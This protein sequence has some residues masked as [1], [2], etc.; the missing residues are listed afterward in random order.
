MPGFQAVRIDLR[1]RLSREVV[2]WHLQRDGGNAENLTGSR[3]FQRL[4]IGIG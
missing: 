1:E 3:S 2:K 4:R